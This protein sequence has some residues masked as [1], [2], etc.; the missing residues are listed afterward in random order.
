MASAARQTVTN[1]QVF[2][3]WPA[4]RRRGGAFSR[5]R[6]F[7]RQWSERL[8]QRAELARLDERS[9]HDIGRSDADVHRELGKWFWQE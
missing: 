2:L 6:A 7:L 9:L 4:P 3:R 8:Q 1:S 5:A